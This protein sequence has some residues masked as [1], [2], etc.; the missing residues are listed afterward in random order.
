[1]RDRMGAVAVQ[2][3]RAYAQPIAES[4]LRAQTTIDR[5]RS[6]LGDI[7][8]R[9]H[10]EASTKENASAYYPRGGRE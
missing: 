10:P 3:S 9:E 7:V 2:L 6:K 5:L 4:A 1:M 8:F